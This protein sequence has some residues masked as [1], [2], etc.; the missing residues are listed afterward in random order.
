[1][2]V[3]GPWTMDEFADQSAETTKKKQARSGVNCFTSK[4]AGEERREKTL[5]PH[6]VEISIRPRAK[7]EKERA[8]GEMRIAS[9]AAASWIGKN[10]RSNRQKGFCVKTATF[11]SFIP[12]TTATFY[13]QN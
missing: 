11:T 8:R 12:N 10:L 1:M 5:C 6:D 9:A 7:A 13:I 2:A 4:D 3:Y